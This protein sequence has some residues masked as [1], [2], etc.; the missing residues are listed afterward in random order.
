M[1]RLSLFV[2]FLAALSAAHGQKLT[3]PAVADTPANRMVAAKRYLKAVPP[4]DMVTETIE[5]VAAQIPEDRREDFKKALSKVVNSQ[6]I[7]ALTLEA[8]TKHFTVR[9]INALTAFYSS[10]EG[11]S[12][13]KK[14]GQYMEDIMPALQDEL[15]EA[16]EEIHKEVP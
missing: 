12:I 11:M 15:S 2:L 4:A 7:E 13:S 1:K 10:P 3:T 8:V 14:F 16:M 6:R 5:R 9:E